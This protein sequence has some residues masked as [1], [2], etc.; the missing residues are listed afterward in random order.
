M[1]L[2]ENVILLTIANIVV[3]ITLGIASPVTITNIKDFFFRIKTLVES[4][5]WMIDGALAGIKVIGYDDN[6]VV[7]TPT[8]SM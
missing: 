5:A 1:Q 7:F 4:V 2:L 6:K 8:C 3:A